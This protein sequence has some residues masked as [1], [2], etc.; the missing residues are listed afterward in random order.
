MDEQ[1]ALI[2]KA[3]LLSPKEAAKSWATF[4][5]RFP[6]GEASSLLSWAAGY[7]HE[8]L[9]KEGISDRYLWGIYQH[10]LITNASILRGTDSCIT[11]LSRNTNL[12]RL[13]SFARLSEG[14]RLG[15][16]P[17]ADVDVLIPPRSLRSSV[18]I[19]RN[20]GFF[21]GLGVSEEELWNR[22]LPQRSSWG[23]EN[24]GGHAIDIHWR[25]FPHKPLA[26]ERSLIKKLKRDGDSKGRPVRVLDPASEIVLLSIQ[27]RLQFQGINHLLIDIWRLCKTVPL[28][29]VLAVAD[30]VDA[31]KWLEQS[32]RKLSETVGDDADFLIRSLSQQASQ[33]PAQMVSAH[34]HEAR[35]TFRARG[36]KVRQFGPL[37]SFRSWVLFLWF[38]FG[39]S[40]K[41][42]TQ[43]IANLGYLSPL[44]IEP[45]GPDLWL[46]R[47]S[48][49]KNVNAGWTYRSPARD[50]V[51]TR[52]PEGRIRFSGAEMGRYQ[53]SFRLM[54]DEWNRHPLAGL[55]LFINGV[56]AKKITKL[57]S[58]ATFEI[59][60]QLVGLEFSF[61]RLDGLY[62]GT[63]GIF[64][65]WYEQMV[66]L[67]LITVRRLRE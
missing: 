43:L 19:L 57:S 55:S 62:F 47:A 29:E 24:S 41:L 60:N 50:F 28:H 16:R 22:V 6:L 65:E 8:N 11:E 23:F 21:P 34:N 51:W 49:E 36:S 59:E 63:P 2:L 17:L 20:H 42:E 46:F 53:V 5:R 35:S 14:E 30:A 27:Q 39:S 26:F 54:K 1:Q 31:R 33:P 40:P 56:E 25:V 9:L 66:P 38:L 58:E 12:V 67:E 45:Q 4:R 64:H 18:E 13:K 37:T 7:V 3:A 48:T 44:A 61:R 15:M 52:Y 10:N 32:F